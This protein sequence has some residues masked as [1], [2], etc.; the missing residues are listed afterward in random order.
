[1]QAQPKMATKWAPWWVYFVIIVG[2]NYVR[3]GT[4][5]DGSSPEIRV[6]IALGFS[7]ALCVIITLIYRAAA[8]R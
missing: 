2:A 3:R 8:R 4:S 5:P 6:V 1:M 7:A